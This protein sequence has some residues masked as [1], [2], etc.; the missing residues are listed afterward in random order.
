MLPRSNSAEPRLERARVV[1]ELVTELNESDSAGLDT[2]NE[3]VVKSSSPT[4]SFADR[5]S[6]SRHILHET[7]PTLQLG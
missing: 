6:L 4:T 1:L 2:Q 7:W 5:K 3:D